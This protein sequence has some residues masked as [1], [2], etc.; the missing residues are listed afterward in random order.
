M[1]RS[2]QDSQQA[3]AAAILIEISKFHRPKI[4]PRNWNMFFGNLAEISKHQ[5]ADLDVINSLCTELLGYTQLTQCID[6]SRFISS[7]AFCF[8]HSALNLLFPFVFSKNLSD[9]KLSVYTSQ[10]YTYAMPRLVKI[11]VTKFRSCSPKNCPTIF[12]TNTVLR[13]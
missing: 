7:V 6:K 9:Y 3:L 1:P 8:L 5:H 12:T 13:Y 2:H 11:I 10:Y 4:S